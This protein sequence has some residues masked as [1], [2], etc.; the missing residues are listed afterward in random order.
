MTVKRR[1]P[2]I[3]KCRIRSVYVLM[4][5]SQLIVQCI[6]EP[7]NCGAGTW[8]NVITHDQSGKELSP[9]VTPEI[10]VMVYNSRA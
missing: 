6:V 7:G 5:T 8:T 4:M 2:H 9:M 10:A 1:F 3:D